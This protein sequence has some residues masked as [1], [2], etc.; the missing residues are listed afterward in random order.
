MEGVGGAYA[1]NILKVRVLI[2]LFGAAVC[3]SPTILTEHPQPVCCSGDLVVTR[4][5]GG[6]Q[7]MAKQMF[8]SGHR[9]DKMGVVPVCACLGLKHFL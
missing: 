8:V 3:V 9:S 5:R 4:G 2:F 6:V 1:D 7:A